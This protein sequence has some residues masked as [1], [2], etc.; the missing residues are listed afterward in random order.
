MQSAQRIADIVPGDRV[1][2]QMPNCLAYPIAVFGIL[3]IGGK[4]TQQDFDQRR[5]SLRNDVTRGG[6]QL[7]GDHV[8]KMGANVDFLNY[9]AVKAF[10][11]NPVFQYRRD[12]NWARPFRAGFG[13][14]DPDVET[15]NTQFGVYA[16]D[17]WSIGRNPVS[18]NS[19]FS[20]MS[21]L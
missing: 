19:Q 3:R 18:E 20:P 13:F 17:D 6:V 11:Q 21:L 12:E 5:I 15:D 9:K 8:F 16:Q 2:I 14:G 1:A 7:A 10:T 4:D